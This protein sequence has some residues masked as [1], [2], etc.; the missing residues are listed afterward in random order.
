MCI[1]MDLYIDCYKW[2]CSCFLFFFY[3]SYILY[4]I[5]FDIQDNQENIV[6]QVDQ[7]AVKFSK[8]KIHLPHPDYFAPFVPPE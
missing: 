1:C 2:A 7:L 3:K 4:C 5:V 6:Q 8:Y